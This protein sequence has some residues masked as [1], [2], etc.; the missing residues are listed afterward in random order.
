MNK[1][2]SLLALLCLSGLA[3]AGLI[4]FNEGL[5]GSGTQ[6]EGT[7][8]YDSFGVT[9]ESSVLFGF[10]SRLP[11]DGWGVTNSPS[12]TGVV[13]FTSAVTSID[14]TWATAV[15]STD[16]YA[17]AFDSLNNVVDSFFFDGALS[18]D[19][20]GVASLTGSGITRLEY[21][22]SGSV[23]AIDTLSFTTASVPEPASLALLGLGLA[24]IGFS[25]KKKI[26]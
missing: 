11:D 26:V 17:T 25:R 12:S 21:H 9:F 4:T 3:N 24:G 20:F 13:N 18:S 15:V 22:D 1:I 10:D 7:S 16:F 14:L 5:T 6:L 19:T 23:V 8:F 2:L